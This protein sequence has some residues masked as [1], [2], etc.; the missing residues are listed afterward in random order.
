MFSPHL[1]VQSLDVR[2]IHVVGGRTD[3]FIFL[4]SKYVNSNQV[5]LERRMKPQHLCILM[6]KLQIKLYAMYYEIWPLT[7]S[8]WHEFINMI[9]WH[10]HACQ[11]WR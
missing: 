7:I 5:H 1:I 2:N 9:P 10:V 6:I 8:L 4:S 11:S 3:I